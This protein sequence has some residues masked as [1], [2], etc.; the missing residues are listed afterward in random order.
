MSLTKYLELVKVFVDR[1]SDQTSFL[2]L[3][4][5]WLQEVEIKH[6][7]NETTADSSIKKKEKTSVDI[8][9]G[10]EWSG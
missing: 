5:F 10:I 6:I 8:P 2:R 3:F 4:P 7:T 1:V 9:L